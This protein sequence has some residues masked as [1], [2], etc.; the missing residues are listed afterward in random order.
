MEFHE[1]LIYARENRASDVHIKVGSGPIIRVD[2]ELM[3]LEGDEYTPEMT[4]AIVKNLVPEVQYDYLLEKGELDMAYS[5]HD[6]GRFRINIYRQRG[7][8]CL[9]L[10]VVNFEIPSL[11]QLEIPTSVEKLTRLKHGLI[12]VTG[13]TG[14]GK[15]TTLASMIQT[16]N[17][18]RRT[19]IMTLED[20]IE[21]LF[22]NDKSIIGQREIGIDSKSFT[23]ALRACLRQ[24]PDIILVGEMRDVE[25]I[26]IA[27]I[28]AETGHLVLSTLHTLG[29]A[30]TVDRII[31]AFPEHNKDTIRHQVASTLQAVVSQQLLPRKTGIGRIP[32]CEILIADDA[33]RN[34]IRDSKNYQLVNIIQ[35]GKAKGMTTMDN[36][37]SR[38]YR[39]GSITREVAIEQALDQDEFL[40]SIG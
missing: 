39:L 32:A 5:L 12:L 40:N 2:G 38:V 10:R 22:K 27:L 23:N 21:Y 20:P 4:E 36:S 14:S 9:A 29:G 30:K 24:D 18:K 37:L 11:K 34:L 17:Q 8:Y 15:S 3:E 16:I 26:K 1:L 19:H 13:P 28:A 7:S 35:Q 6:I 33:A 31:D 25:T